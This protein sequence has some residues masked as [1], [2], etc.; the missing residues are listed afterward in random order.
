[1]SGQN[2]VAQCL[3]FTPVNIGIIQQSCLCLHLPGSCCLLADSESAASFSKLRCI[4]TKKKKRKFWFRHRQAELRV[5]QYCWYWQEYISRT[6]KILE[7]FGHVS[8][9]EKIQLI[10]LEG[11]K[12]FWKYNKGLKLLTLCFKLLYTGNRVDMAPHLMR[13]MNERREPMH[14]LMEDCWPS[15]FTVPV[16]RSKIRPASTRR[17]QT[18]H[19]LCSG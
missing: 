11:I 13:Q 15:F 6:L 16:F 4:R 1:M 17:I 8:K 12:G 2:I 14:I 5:L 18:R 3:V 19:H 9:G 7:L 10:Y